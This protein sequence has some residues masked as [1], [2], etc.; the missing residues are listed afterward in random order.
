[1]KFFDP[2]EDV[3]DLKLTQYG[4]HLLSKGKLIPKFYAFFDDDVIYDS[5]WVTGSLTERQ[6]DIEDRIQDDTPRL[7][8]QT[9]YYGVETEITKINELVRQQQA[10]LGDD[11]LQPLASRHHVMTHP[12]GNSS[13]STNKM[14][15]WEAYFLI[16]KLTGSVDHMT[17]SSP[18]IKI[19]QLNCEVVYRGYAYAQGDG[20]TAD[21]TR[22]LELGTYTD[23]G[24]DSDHVGMWGGEL[25]FDDG[26]TLSIE[27]DSIIIEIDESNTDYLN[28]NFDI[29]VYEIQTVAASGSQ[30][31]QQNK[32]ETEELIPL[33]FS[34][35]LQND[36]GV[37]YVGSSQAQDIGTVFPDIDPNYVEYFFE[38]NVDREIDRRTICENLPTQRARRGRLQAEFKCPDRAVDPIEINTLLGY[39]DGLYDSSVSDLDDYEDCD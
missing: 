12:L 5:R 20:P 17:G 4:K 26:S 7:K 10:K 11:R 24:A 30:Q 36:L 19:P 21:E 33:Y 37:S 15:G 9:C 13:L 3:M 31:P 32:G 39:A 22:G 18:N 25:E 1:M 29:E 28:H 23:E 14:P 35:D 2:K 6:S 16:G 27:K 34:Q 8:L 38:V